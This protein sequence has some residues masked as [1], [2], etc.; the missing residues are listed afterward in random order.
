M[1]RRVQEARMRC[2]RGSPADKGLFGRCRTEFRDASYDDPGMMADDGT[3]PGLS[4]SGY[5]LDTPVE[6]EYAEGESPGLAAN[7]DVRG[8]VVARKAF[9]C[10]LG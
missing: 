4:E 10:A 6:G 5:Y 3:T 9:D 8:R 7:I 1:V 2:C